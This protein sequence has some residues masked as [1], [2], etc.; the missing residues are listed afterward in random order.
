MWR[1]RWVFAL[2]W[3]PRVFRVAL[4]CGLSVLLAACASSLRCGLSVRSCGL[5]VLACAPAPFGF[6]PRAAPPCSLRPR[7]YAAA[8]LFVLCFARLRSLRSA[9][10]ARWVPGSLLCRFAWLP[11]RYAQLPLRCPLPPC[12]ASLRSAACG[13]A[14]LGRKRPS[15]VRKSPNKSEKVRGWF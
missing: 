3:V 6:R 11:P 10:L 5:S 7:G 12:A 9:R 2:P 4:R 13:L 1:H 14:S 15:R 8:P